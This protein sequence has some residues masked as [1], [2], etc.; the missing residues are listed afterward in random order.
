[1]IHQEPDDLP[2]L[3]SAVD[4]ET[5]LDVM[6]APRVDP[7]RPEMTGL[8]LIAD[9]SLPF[10]LSKGYTP[11]KSPRLVFMHLIRRAAHFHSIANID[12]SLVLVLKK[13]LVDT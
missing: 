1:M 5:Y 8:M 3:E 6:S 4:G 7:A 12:N 11:V 9:G 10:C 13:M 2:Q